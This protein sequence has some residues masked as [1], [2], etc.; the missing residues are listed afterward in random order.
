MNYFLKANKNLVISSLV[1]LIVFPVLGLNFFMSFIGNI[2]LLFFLIPVFLLLL[3][4][5]GLNS[6]ISKINRCGNCGSI[7]L[8][9]SA[10]FYED[11]D[12]IPEGKEVGDV[13]EYSTTKPE[14]QSIDHSKLTP[15]LTAALQE[16]VAKIEVLESKVASLG[17]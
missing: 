10:T 2:L 5:L 8:G 17:G 16:A 7:S 11:G 12:S 6:Y 1:I 9:L 4:F 3:I 15:L 13:K 14:Y